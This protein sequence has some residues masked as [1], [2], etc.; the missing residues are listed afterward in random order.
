[1]R[2]SDP[3]DGGPTWIVS[4]A[5]FHLVPPV[6]GVMGV[7]LRVLGVQPGL[8][9]STT[10]RGL[11]VRDRAAYRAWALAAIKRERPRRLLMS[12]GEP[13]EGEDL[14]ERLAAIVRR[15]L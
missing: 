10:F 12:H 6:T 5:F 14:P 9:L 3:G 4:D 15:R 2:G 8:R 11:C 13:V 7:A 1:V